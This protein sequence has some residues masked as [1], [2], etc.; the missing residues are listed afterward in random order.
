M[1]SSLV[2][3]MRGR[4]SHSESGRATRGR[5]RGGASR[6]SRGRAARRARGPCRAARRAPGRARCRRS[7]G[8]PPP[9]RRARC[10]HGPSRAWFGLRDAR[11]RGCRV[12]LSCVASAASSRSLAVVATPLAERAGLARPAA[13]WAR[14]RLLPSRSPTRL[15]ARVVT[16]RGTRDVARQEVLEER[17]DDRR[18]RQREDR[19]R[20]CPRS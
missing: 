17:G 9:N 12:G 2:T 3:R 4:E 8:A 11:G 10:V 7:A 13:A 6:R 14:A 19:R 16:S 5:D 15:A 18:E 1:P 20:R